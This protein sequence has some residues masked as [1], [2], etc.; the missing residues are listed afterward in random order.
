MRRRRCPTAHPRWHGSD[1]DQNQHQ[2]N[3]AAGLGTW[4][5]SAA[6]RATQREITRVR[7]EKERLGWPNVAPSTTSDVHTQRNALKLSNEHNKRPQIH[8]T[9][10]VRGP[11]REISNTGSHRS[12]VHNSVPTNGPHLGLVALPGPCGPVSFLI[13][14]CR[15]PYPAPACIGPCG[16]TRNRWIS[17]RGKK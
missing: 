4:A 1:A 10:A 12:L 16:P 14:R 8:E 5:G 15:P 13:I 17:R 7:W 3:E 6:C 9:I 11:P 2:H